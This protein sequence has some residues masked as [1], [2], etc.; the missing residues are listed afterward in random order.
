MTD[1]C[2]LQLTAHHLGGGVEGEGHLQ[3]GQVH[4]LQAVGLKKRLM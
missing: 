3:G 1:L 4:L 2:A